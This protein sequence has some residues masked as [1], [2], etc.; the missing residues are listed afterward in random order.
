M[1]GFAVLVPALI[2]AYDQLPQSDPLLEELKAPIDILKSWDY[3]SG[4]TSIATTL[5]ME[6]GPRLS[7]GIR[8][9][10]INPGEKDQVQSTTEFARTARPND[11]L[12]PLKATVSD[13]TKRFGKWQ[14]PWGEIN[15]FQ[16]LTGQVREIYDDNAPSIAVGFGS[17][18]WGHLASFVSNP[19]KT[20]KRYGY[21]GNSFICA[22]EFGKRIKAKSILA[23]GNSGDPN[24]KHFN[25]QT[26]MYA[27]GQ[28]KDVLFYKEDVIK[29]ME[30]SYHP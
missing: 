19:F 8:K 23:G 26:K 29:N 12:E 22:V 24:S 10:Y 15:R 20:N 17:A 7:A 14:I 13:L 11:L 4:E 30:R 1:P 9:V 28:F 3:R 25:D 16:R 6:W 18:T 2:K 5:A 27:N 21:S